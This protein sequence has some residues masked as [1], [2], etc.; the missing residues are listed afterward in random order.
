MIR[1][2]IEEVKSKDDKETLSV[3]EIYNLGRTTA[4]QNSHTCDFG[5]RETYRS[6]VVWNGVTHNLNDGFWG[7]IMKIIKRN[8]NE[9]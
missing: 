9:I 2:T 7:L 1:V 5:A 8:L 6:T 3:L 4:D